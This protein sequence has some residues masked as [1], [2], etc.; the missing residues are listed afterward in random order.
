MVTAILIIAVAV[1]AIGWG[2]N[3]VNA[4]MLLWYLDKK[5]VP[6]PSEKEMDEGTRWVVSHM[7]E[8]LF[9]FGKER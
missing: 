5:R 8:D 4:L 3:R 9:S 2:V 6:Y 1:C 7:I